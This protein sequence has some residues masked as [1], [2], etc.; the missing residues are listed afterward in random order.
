[1]NAMRRTAGSTAKVFLALLGGILFPVLVWVA[2]GVALSQRVRGRRLNQTPA[3]AP[4]RLPGAAGRSSGEEIYGG[5]AKPCW[6]IL[7]CPSETRETCPSY[8]R[9]DIPAWVAARLSKG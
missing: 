8:A 4:A 1:M 6:E 7:H 5:A 3:P 2:L 9:R